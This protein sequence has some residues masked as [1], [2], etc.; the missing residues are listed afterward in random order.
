MMSARKRSCGGTR[1]GESGRARR[2]GYDRTCRSTSLRLILFAIVAQVSPCFA[3]A[4]AEKTKVVVMV[5]DGMRPDFVTEEYT[6]TLWKL[7][8]EGVWFDHHHSV[9]P[10]ATQVNGTAIAIGAYPGR[11]GLLANREYRAAIRANVAIDTAVEEVVRKGDEVTGGKYLALPTIAERVRTAG[12]TAAIGGSK[13]IA[14]L[15]DRHAE[16]TTARRTE[17]ATVFAA[18]PMP[19]VLREEAERV[20][21][22][23]LVRPTDKNTARN[24]YTTRAVTDLLWRK[25]VP[26]FSLLWLSDPDL[27]QHETAPGAPEAIAA[28]KSSDDNLAAVLQALEARKARGN[29]DLLV[30]SD[31]GFSTITRAVDV[32][33]FLADAGFDPVVKFDEPPKAGQIMVVANGG[34]TLFYVIGGDAAITRRLVDSLQRSDFAG[35]IFTRE[36]MEG[37]FD[38]QTVRLD[39][40]GAPDVVVAMRWSD[41]KN[42][43]GVPGELVADATRAVGNGTHASLSRRDVHNTLVAAGPSFRKGATIRMPSGNIDIAPTTLHLLG[44]EAGEK[45]DGRVLAEAF[46]GG[47]EDMSAVKTETLETRR[48]FG[49][50]QWRQY[51]KTSRVG[52]TIYFDEGNGSFGER[53]P[54]KR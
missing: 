37:T 54:A 39:R 24:A 36:K 52:D 13:S 27:T 5:W 21:G 46:V 7:R 17:L 45:F 48:A 30:V 50:D 44:M 19:P 8:K 6:P 31:H 38:L 14:L 18:A 1:R 22:P 53:E 28:I 51:L 34:S 16:W 4:A 42:R 15:H 2:N 32:P 9:Y 23:L 29:T 47:K 49:S 11:T 33:Q 43:F 35:V 26:D 25:G 3:T 10:T 20:F 40:D 12:K 41:G